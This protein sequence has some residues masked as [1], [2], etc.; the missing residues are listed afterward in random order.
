[1]A[2]TT[3]GVDA[4]GSPSADDFT[5]GWKHSTVVEHAE[6]EA[7]P[8][9]VG[10]AQSM[11]KCT[12][13]LGGW[14]CDSSVTL[15]SRWLVDEVAPA[16]QR[17]RCSRHGGSTAVALVPLEEGCHGERARVNRGAGERRE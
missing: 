5:R 2:G 3:D 6:G 17:L 13:W 9:L 1:V 11:M 4:R 7:G 8:D 14:R 12:Q 15:S 16:A 10:G